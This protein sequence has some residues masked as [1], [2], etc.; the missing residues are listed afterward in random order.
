TFHLPAEVREDKIEA[1]YKDGILTVHLPKAE[2]AKA[3]EIDIKV[4]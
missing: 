4:S 1:S 3:K 2:K